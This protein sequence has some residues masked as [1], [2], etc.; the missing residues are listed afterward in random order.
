MPR[1]ILK[2]V[3][4]SDKA[5][6]TVT[7]RVERS[8]LHPVYKKRIRRHERYQAHDEGNTHVVGDVVE[9][10]ESRPI[11]KNKRWVVMEKAV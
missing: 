1:R 11:S 3:V 10:L 5:D 6:K 9:I 4:V 8:V 2:G 7:V